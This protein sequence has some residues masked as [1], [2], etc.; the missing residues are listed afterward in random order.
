[1]L[2]SR[3][4]DAVRWLVV[5]AV[6]TTAALPTR[7]YAY[8]YGGEF[9]TPD[10]VL[11]ERIN[12]VEEQTGLISEVGPVFA[13]APPVLAIRAEPTQAL[14][15]ERVSFA[16]TVT[17]PSTATL[18]SL[19]VEG[20]LPEPLEL[21]PDTARG[22]GF[23]PATRRL[24]WRLPQ[25]PPGRSLEA[26]FAARMGGAA[27][28]QRFTLALTAQGEGMAAPV[29]SWVDVWAEPPAPPRSRIGPAGGAVASRVHGVVVTL[30]AGAVDR[31]VEVAIGDGPG[32]LTSS[33]VVHAFTLEA[34]DESR[35]PVITFGRPVT[36]TVSFAAHLTALS[37]QQGSPAVFWWDE[38]AAQWRSL[39]SQVDW[40]RLTATA[41]VDHFSTFGLGATQALS[42]GAQH[43]PTVHGFVTDEWSGNSGV[44]YPLA[45]P[46]GPGGLG[47]NLSLSY[48]SEGVNSIRQGTGY[49]NGVNYDQQNGTTFARQ[50]S[51]I[52]WGWSLQGLGQVTVQLGGA[53][54][55]RAWLGYAG[56]GYELKY[57][58][59]QWQTEP[60]SFLRIEHQGD[61]FAVSPWVVWAPDGVKYTFGAGDGSGIA[62]NVNRDGNGNCYRL[63]RELH[64]TEVQDT[65]GNRV[66]VSY[67]VETKNLPTGYCA[68]DY[69]PY[70]QYVRAIRPMRVE[71]LAQDQSSLASVRVDF[72]YSSRSDTGVPG[73]N[74]PYVESYWSQWRLTRIEVKVRNGD[75]TDSFALARAYDL[76]QDYL[77]QDQGAGKGLLRLT[78]ITARG[79]DNGALPAW[80][81]TYETK[82]GWLNHTLLSTAS[83]GQGGKVTYEYA[84]VA[85]IWM[86]PCG[87]NTQRY[88]VS[89]QTL[90]DGLGSAAHNIVRREYTHGGPF[91]WASGAPT[92]TD[93]FEFGGY[94]SVVAE[95]KNGSGAVAQAVESQFHQC[96]SSDSSGQN[97]CGGNNTS[98][99]PRR[100]KAFLRI[101]RTQA[102]G[103]ELARTETTWKTQTEKGTNWVYRE[104]E[105]QTLGSAAQK[106]TYEYQAALQG[107]QQ[108]GNV[109]HVRTYLDAGST[110]LRT[111][112]TEYFPRNETNRY[113]VNRPARRQILNAANQCQ[114]ETRYVYDNQ[115]GYTVPPTLGDLTKVRTALTTCGT[116]WSD[117]SYGYDVWGNQTTVTD[118]L[119]NTTTTAYE[120][121]GA[122]PK[123]YALPTKVTTQILTKDNQPLTIDTH[124]TWDKVLGQVTAVTDPNG[125]ITSYE[126]D[127][128]GR[129]VKEIRPGDGSTSPT[130][131][132]T[133]TN[134][135]GATAPYRVTEERQDG[136]AGTG[137]L[138]RYTFYDGLGR[139]VQT[140][141][142]AAASNQSILVSFQYNPLGLVTKENVPYFYA[143]APGV[144]RT[145][146]WTQSKTETTYD[147]LGRVTKVIHPDGTTTQTHYQDRQ[148]AVI[149]ALNRQT[150]REMDGLGRLIRVKQYTTTTGLNWGA[151]V[152]AETTYAY[153]VAD[154]LTKVTGPD[155]AAIEVEYDLAGRKTKVTDPNMGVWTYAYDAAGNLTRQTD[156][157]GQT[158]CF[159]YD[160][161]NRLTG[162]H[163][164]TDITCP[165]SNPTLTVSYTYDQ[166][167]NGKGR[168]TGMTD[169]S[170]STSWTYDNRGRVTEETKVV[171]GTDGGTFK[172]QWG[173]DA[174]DRVAWMKYPGGNG[175]QIG[176]QVNF[177]YNPMGLLRQVQS[178]G[179]TYYVGDTTYNALGQVELRRLGSTTGVLTTDYL[180]RT[181]NFRLQWIKTGPTSPYE[182]LQNLEYVYDAVGN[183]LTIKDY[184]VTGGTQTQ[185]F[186]YD[187]LDRLLS[188]GASGGSS[189][190]GQY[191]ESYTYNASGNLMSKTGVGSYTYG[192][193]ASDC[194]EGALSKPHAVVTAGSNTYCY[195]QNGNLRRR[196]IG[197]TTYTLTYDAE[198]RL[199]GVSGGA[200]ASFVYDG[201]GQ[202]VKAT[203]NGTTTVV[204]GPSGLDGHYRQQQRD[205]S[206]RAALQ[207]L[208]GDALHLGHHAHGLP[209]YRPAGRCYHWAVR[210]KHVSPL[211]CRHYDPVLGRFLQPD[212]LVPEPGNPQ[213]LNRKR[214]GYNMKGP[215]I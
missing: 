162:K 209:L 59:G 114:G 8:V 14:P 21:L 27:L 207:G 93:Y 172:T 33:P 63:A 197:A 23:D 83:N 32:A 142:E 174:M 130:V 149:D 106:T 199:T 50:A 41:V 52:G 1:M 171:S 18:A 144:Y 156:A 192:T 82:N 211:H 44:H 73:Q 97:P 79:K 3:I 107:G 188:A 153:D 104:S 206:G 2:G 198:N 67:G 99:D 168:R 112:V 183:V 193:Q 161:L 15:G 185:S 94:R 214:S 195:D 16:V 154:R 66:K 19:V 170:G 12:S 113:I 204:D 43:L 75:G 122:W 108:Y 179:S 126:Y 84:N 182:G 91:A 152:Y 13:S 143:A 92:C 181:D 57:V 141:A 137:Y 77:W 212:P 128:W 20:V 215:R 187:P 89:Q 100:G 60:Q 203:F 160:R 65:H 189:G 186:T 165:T 133:Y 190:Q 129:V 88:R 177:T 25:L 121:S 81:F 131:R 119:G 123:L 103:A 35:A 62:W 96:G 173:Y 164:R 146:D 80:S 166:G 48:S 102:G 70:N 42:Y 53:G 111:E 194:P 208:G 145:P 109:T 196:K 176:E 24:S 191:S 135:A 76:T 148:V 136:S 36:I 163:Y 6:A 72:L 175:G 46:P 124:Y 139:V 78:H 127:Q 74:D 49:A 90:E 178:H 22:V 98:M 147:A 167:T 205:A 116:P 68:N 158:I 125:A 184:K 40:A 202:R 150:I 213:G 101:T 51:A 10:A 210:A 95:V 169:G 64:L 17:N 5:V 38:A 86:H 7:A 30:P 39:P 34:V 9:L 69:A 140:Q 151:A 61:G 85:N 159:Y 29:T 56:G 11:Q 118:P 200:S 45:L 4:A 120:T 105:T 58:N 31:A 132:Y 47:V 117:V 115:S 157:R 138:E 28:G 26:S 87:Q 71:Y 180:Y 37:E 201:D 110:L 155:N 134:Y 55:G 54:Q